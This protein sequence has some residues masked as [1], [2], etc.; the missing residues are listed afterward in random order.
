M[1]IP[2]PIVFRKFNIDML[3]INTKK[4][5][6]LLFTY[7]IALHLILYLPR[8]VRVKKITFSVMC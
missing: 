1:L 3:K 8:L 4:T 7:V 6:F 5:Y 2:R